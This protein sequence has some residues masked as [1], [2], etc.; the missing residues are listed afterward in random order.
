MCVLGGVKKNTPYLSW[1]S[2]IHSAV[3]LF[4]FST[5][6]FPGALKMRTDCSNLK[7]QPGD[8]VFPRLDWSFVRIIH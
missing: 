3:Q 8:Q 4:R 7:E 5:A 6:Q 2:S 1:G